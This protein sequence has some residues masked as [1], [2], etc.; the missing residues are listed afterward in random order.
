[1]RRADRLWHLIPA[2]AW[3]AILLGLSGNEA[4]AGHTANIVELIVKATIGTVSD[5]AFEAIHFTIRKAAHVIAY[6]IAGALNFYA[7]RGSRRGWM[8]KWAVL[9]VTFAAITASLDEW[10]QSYFP[11]RTGVPSDVVIDI[12]GAVLAQLILRR[13][14]ARGMIA[15]VSSRA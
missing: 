8:L 10:H 1:M 12:C 4:S 14:A 15:P 5:P 7:A 11:S 9:A 2:L 13:L 3:A 6:G